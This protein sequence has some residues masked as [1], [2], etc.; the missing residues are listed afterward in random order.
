[1][2]KF[3]RFNL[4]SYAWSHEDEDTTK[5]P[6]CIIK[7]FGWNEKN[8]SVYV[9]VEDFQLPIYIELPDE[10]EWTEARIMTACNR[11]QTLNA[12]HQLRPTTICYEE[13]QRSY[14]AH[15]NKIPEKKGIKYQHKKFPYL[16]ALFPSTKACESF[17][18]VLR[19]EIM[20][21]GIGKIKLKCHAAERTITPVLKFLAV[22][23]LPSAGWMISKGAKLSK[24]EK[25]ST[26]KHEYCIS[27]SD[28]IAMSEEKS[29]KM[30]IIS[31]KIMSFDN[32]ANSTIMSSMPKSTRPG[33]KTFQIGYTML[34][35]P[36]NGKP[37]K[38]RKY[39]LSLGN[40]SP[41]EDVTVI[42]YKTEADLYAGFSKNMCTEDPD[43]VLGFNI[44]GWDLNYMIERSKNMCRCLGE[45]DLMGCIPGKHA[46]EG[47][48]S[49]GSSAYGKQEFKYLEADGRL[50]IDMLPYIKRNYKLPNYRLETVCDEFLKTNKDPIKPKDIFKCFRLYQSAKDKPTTENIKK[51]SEALARIGKYCVQDSFVCILL[52]EKLLVWADLT[53][54]ATVNNV[55]IFD[56]FTKGQQIK[57]YSQVYRYCFHNNI[58]VESNAYISKDDEHFTGAYVSEPLKGLYD[59]II[60]FDF[61]SLYPSIMMAYNIDYSKMVLDHSI[62][63]KDCHVMKW[64]EHHYCGCPL[65]DFPGK[66]APVSLDGTSRRTCAD[67]KYRWLKQEV[68][69]KGIIPTLLENVLGARKKTRNIIYTNDNELK[70]I[71]KIVHENTLLEDDIIILN[72]H[73][74]KISKNK[75]NTSANTIL[76][77]LFKNGYTP[78]ILSDKHKIIL[79][80]RI[81]SLTALNSVLDRRQI[82]F[83][84]NANSMYGATG[85][86][87]GY[88]P[89][90]PAAMCVT[91]MGRTNIF[92]ANK[93]LEEECGGKVIYND[94][95]SAYCYFEKFKNSSPQELWAYAN[96]IV[97]DVKVLFPPPMSLEFE[98]KIYKKFLILTKKRYVAQSM[99]GEGVIDSK[100][101]KR[102]IVLQR[103]DNC[104]ILRQVY[105]E[106]VF[107]V[108]DNH[109]TLV[110]LKGMNQ[111]EV[112][113]NPVVID[114]LNMIIFAIDTLFQW[115]Y[116]FKDYVITKQ[117]TRDVKEYKNPDRLPGHVLLGVKMKKRG[118]PIG[119]GSRIEYVIINKKSYR[120]DAPQKDKI[121][122]V[123]Y[124]A[125][126]REVFR[127]CRISYLKQ[128][129]NPIDEI[130][131]TVMGIKG[132][133]KSH[134]ETRIKYSK[135]VDRIKDLG[136]AKLL[137]ID[138]DMNQFMEF[139]D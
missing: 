108:F 79:K 84:V 96:K 25:E 32:E 97:Q 76:L 45:L 61:A 39:L 33:D 34:D 110:S 59:M 124:F 107:K 89:F 2:S 29:I 126:F 94:T 48:I 41:I 3:E 102:G 55:P 35:P 75:N 23:Q 46:P 139:E 130:C 92:K 69:G 14:Y 105:Q 16:M 11:L 109:D 72:T 71:K 27:F 47:L 10:I 62:P 44:L 53:E 90:I 87:K 93:F 99:N 60:P 63:D 123:N 86:K 56:M 103:R 111:K 70:F 15:V 66:K 24:D 68:S 80:E 101:L 6:Q 26:R 77:E 118:V 31:P 18:N 117:I 49:W 125:E 52:Y 57:Q 104:I 54:S 58:V 91:F 88:L 138:V 37:K 119:A 51:A 22:R 30:P 106:L 122:D 112:L 120:K 21:S 85:T 134:F 78:I 98:N 114:L 4:F 135:V 65:D 132:F 113:S 116:G 40:P 43:V 95:D 133:V 137:F 64:S 128:F 81:E 129:I 50:F 7:I 20:I 12:N 121:E 42:T 13:R 83:K 131:E 115:K 1:M 19:R 74:S 82:A 9:R 8:E 127:L 73:I 17:T 38:Y 136:E 36:R 5:G 67:F 28:I 100:L